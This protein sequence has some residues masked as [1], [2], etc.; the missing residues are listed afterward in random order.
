MG[1]QGL[2]A[3]DCETCGCMFNGFC[4]MQRKREFFVE[5]QEIVAVVVVVLQVVVMARIQRP[6]QAGSYTIGDEA[7]QVRAVVAYR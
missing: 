3:V 7:G 6:R 4:V 5:H 1:L 2:I